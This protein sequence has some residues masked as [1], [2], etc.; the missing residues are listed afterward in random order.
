MSEEQNEASG[1]ASTNPPAGD[2]SPQVRGPLRFVT[3]IIGLLVVVAL[4]MAVAGFFLPREFD[5]TTSIYLDRPPQIA[6]QKINDLKAWQEWC[7]WNETTMPGMV[8]EYGGA[9]QGLGAEWTWQHESG[10]GKQWITLS[11]LNLEIEVATEFADFPPM[12]SVFSFEPEDRGTRITWRTRGRVND[13]PMD[14]WMCLM[15]PSMM[16]SEYDKGLQKLVQIVE[17]QQPEGGEYPK[18]EASDGPA[19][20]AGASGGG[21]GGP[22][23]GR[24]GSAGGGRGRGGRGGEAQVT[25]GE[26]SDSPTANEGNATPADEDTESN[27][28]EDASPESKADGSADAADDEQDGQST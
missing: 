18:V 16:T 14:G 25:E 19:P 12:T 21:M 11:Q 4:V 26:S 23:G 3:F 20:V 10:D 27:S 2:V 15:M 8:N 7:P 6:F 24:G 28:G 13:G 22:G 9:D 17:E 1:T 5:V